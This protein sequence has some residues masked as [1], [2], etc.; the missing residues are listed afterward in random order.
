MAS[1][2]IMSRRGFVAGA[3]AVV[4]CAGIGAAARFLPDSANVLRPPGSVDE[5]EF[6]ARCIHCERCIS[7]CP[8]D[9][10]EPAGIE[11]GVLQV[12][13]PVVSFE[14]DCCTFCQKCYEVCPTD[15]IEPSDPFV[16]VPGRIGVAEVQPDRCLAYYTRGS[17]GVCVENCPYGAVSFNEERLPVVDED[18]CN[19]CGTCER[20]CPA[21]VLTSFSGGS[22]RGIIVVTERTHAE[23]GG[24]L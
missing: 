3:G 17:C 15:A 24:A 4:V 13:T 19:G 9:I 11:V 20:D 12:R 10:L 21:N 5:D 7:V 14:K 22:D 8:T 16:P 6:L 23:E 18:L 2:K 1:S